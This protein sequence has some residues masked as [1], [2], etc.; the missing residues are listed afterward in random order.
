MRDWIT[1]DLNWKIFSIVLAVILWVTVHKI[2][3]EPQTEPVVESGSTFTY[4]NLPVTVVS[5]TADVHDFRVAPAAVRV[6]VTGPTDIMKTLQI[7]QVHAVVDL[8][9]TNLAHDTSLPVEISTPT[10]VTVTG[11]DPASVLVAVPPASGKK[12]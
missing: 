7:G 12:P 9:G 6:T 11:I 5:A 10:K 8:T 2:Y 4:D 3:E 1:Q